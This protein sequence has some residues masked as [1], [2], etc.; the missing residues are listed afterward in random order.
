[1][2]IIGVLIWYSG[3]HFWRSY[4]LGDTT[5]DAEFIVWPSKLLVPVAFS[6]WFLRL[7]IQLAGSIRLFIDP[8][9]DPQGVTLMKDAAEVAREEAQQAT[10][11]KET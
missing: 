3:A 1:M 6:L 4:Q 7:A 9:K 10:E 8:S 5:I 2:V 11:T